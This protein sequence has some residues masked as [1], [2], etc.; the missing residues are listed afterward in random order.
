MNTTITT[1]K[2]YRNDTTGY[3][4][5][6]ID[7][8]RGY[9]TVKDS[10]GYDFP[11]VGSDYP[12]AATLAASRARLNG[13]VEVP[14]APVAQMESPLAPADR[15]ASFLASPGATLI[16]PSL[17]QARCLAWSDNGDAEPFSRRRIRRG[18]ASHVGMTAPLDVLIAMSRR[19]WVILDHPT[20]PMSAMMTDTGKRALAT[21]IAQ[22]GEVL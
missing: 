6:L 3:R 9:A 11:M 17:P 8:N 20:M 16:V 13:A 19:G 7:N 1:T 21:Y 15:K 14:A 4:V 22:H 2:I 5:T 10:N 12:F 18:R